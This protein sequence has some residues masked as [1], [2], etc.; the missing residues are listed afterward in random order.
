MLE[1]QGS[2]LIEGNKTICK[3]KIEQMVG[4][5][6]DD[7]LVEGRLVYNFAFNSIGAPLVVV[8]IWKR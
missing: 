8:D 7:F 6:Q 3:W 1:M 2:R 5:G 4:G